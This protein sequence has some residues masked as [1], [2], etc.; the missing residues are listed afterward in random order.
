MREWMIV[1]RHVADDE[2]ALP[3]FVAGFFLGGAS[4]LEK[5]W[6]LFIDPL[7]VGTHGRRPPQRLPGCLGEQL[8][9]DRCALA[10]DVAEP[11]PRAGLVL[12]RHEPEG[13]ADGL[14]AAMGLPHKFTSA[15]ANQ[16]GER[17]N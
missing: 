15:L 4:E 12:A 7:E 14:G 2:P 16:R 17:C 6:N 13:P 5:D 10:G 1:R 11:A 9:D 3:A 8:A